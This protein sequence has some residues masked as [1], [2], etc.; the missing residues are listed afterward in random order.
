MTVKTPA[1]PDTQCRTGCNEWHLRFLQS[2][3]MRWRKRKVCKPN[4]A[5]MQR[6]L[7]YV[8]GGCVGGGSDRFVSYDRIPAG[9]AV[10]SLNK[11]PCAGCSDKDCVQRLFGH[12]RFVQWTVKIS[13]M[14]KHSTT[15]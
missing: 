4:N 15:P 8:G 13:G 11:G 14:S 12:A 10:E 3:K 2:A 9:G 5:P 6:R 1:P 7:C